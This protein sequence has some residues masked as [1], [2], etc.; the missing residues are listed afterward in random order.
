VVTNAHVVAGESDT[1][2]EVGGAGAGL[3]AQAIDFDPHDDIAILRVS[4]LAGRPLTLA[5]D[6]RAGT[7]AAILGYPEDGPFD[8]QP[9]R[10]G[11]TLDVETQDAYGN[12]PV[13]RSVTQL[14]GHVR[15]GNSGG[16]MVDGAGQVV[17]TVFAAI[18][19]AP[20]SR[21][22]FAV[23]NRLVAAQLHQAESR[24]TPVGTGACAG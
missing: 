6:P 21:G 8:S 17:A 24:E 16:P 18:A 12:G 11:Q 15:P 5:S 2:V 23:P 9:G 13:L 14:L 20:G 1:R 19:G 10:I 7:S 3:A 4:G 22:G